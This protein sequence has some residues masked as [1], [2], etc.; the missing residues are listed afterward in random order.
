MLDAARQAASVQHVVYSSVWGT[1]VY[2]IVPG[3]DRNELGV[4]YWRSKSTGEDL[5]RNGGFKFY[6]ILRPTE[7]MTNYLNPSANFQLG[8]LLKDGT[9]RTPF[10]QGFLKGLI[11]PDDIGRIAATVISAPEKFDRKELEVTADILPVQG[12]LKLLSEASGKEL[13]IQTYEREEA[14][15]L[16][17]ANPLVH[18]Q[19]QRVIQFEQA[20]I[21]NNPGDFGLELKSFKQFLL[22][23][24]AIVV[25]TFKNVP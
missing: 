24:H 8:S 25:D 12:L 4:N 10:P 23:H 14:L 3:W 13:K 17:Q 15:K 9:W 22:E 20:G 1:D 16:A 2:D 11:D 5:V 21:K 18:V 6:T 19:L 7:F